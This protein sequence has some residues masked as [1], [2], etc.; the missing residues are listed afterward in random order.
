MEQ[1][2]SQTYSLRQL[3]KRKNGLQQLARAIS[4]TSGKGG[5]GKSNIAIN[6][7]LVLQE[8]GKNTTILDADLGLANVDVLLGKKPLFN[9]NHVF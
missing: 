5:V 2:S 9:I 3:A 4:I 6:L 8:M 7:G 1:Y